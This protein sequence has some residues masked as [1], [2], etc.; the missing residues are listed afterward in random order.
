MHGSQN[1]ELDYHIQD[2]LLYHVGKI[3]ISQSE[4][5]HVIREAHTS[6]ISWNFGVGKTI[7][8]LQKFWCFPQM[9]DTMSK[10]VEGCVMFAK[11]KPFNMK[12]HF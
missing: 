9:N 5:V 7:S 6:L 12:L 10:Y 4:R 11:T 1:E 8:Q 2:K 3:C